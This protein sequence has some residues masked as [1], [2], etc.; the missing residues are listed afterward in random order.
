MLFELSQRTLEYYANNQEI[1]I[2]VTTELNTEID[3]LGNGIIIEKA[4]R[5]CGD[6]LL[7][8][9]TEK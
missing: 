1:A 7:N 5:L 4:M 6:K 9:Y 8:C 3:E 2:E